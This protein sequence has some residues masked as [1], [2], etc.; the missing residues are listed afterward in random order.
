MATGCGYK[1][2]LFHRFPLDSVTSFQIYGYDSQPT[3]PE[4]KQKPF[5]IKLTEQYHEVCNEWLDD[6]SKQL[7]F[8]IFLCQK[9]TSK[10]LG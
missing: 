5:E 1:E 2:H 6:L 3:N 7:Y 10:S 4:A 9:I 8:N